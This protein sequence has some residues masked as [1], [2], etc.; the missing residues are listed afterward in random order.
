V[1]AGELRP[2]PVTARKDGVHPEDETRSS[3]CSA[4][5]TAAASA[6]RPPHRCCFH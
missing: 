2:S 3:T 4:R 5:T 6:A 1:P